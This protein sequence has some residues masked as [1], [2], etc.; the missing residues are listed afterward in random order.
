ME[1]E[2]ALGIVRLLISGG[3]TNEEAIGNPAIPEHYRKQIQEILEREENIIL[4]PARML[5][6]DT[7]KYDWLR[8]LDRSTWHYWPT[9][10][11]YLLGTKNWTIA[12]IRSLDE[13]TDR[14]L[15]QF[16]DPNTEQFDIRGLVVGYVQSGKTANFTALIAKAAD[17]GYRLV[18]VLSGTD[19]GLRRQTQIRLNRELVGYTNNPVGAIPLPPTGKQWHQFTTEEFDGDFHPGFANYA[20]LQG[21]EPVLLVVKKNG[22]VLRR[23]HDWLDAAPDNT[24]RTLP[25]LL[26]DDEADQ[27]SIDT[28]VLTKRKEKNCLMTM[29]NLLLLTVVYGIYCENSSAKLM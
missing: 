18:I 17:V 3:I 28:R 14:I 21:T 13:V 29:K 11:T 19:N 4:E 1:F 24:R 23:L 10:R 6:A 8:Q 20:A 9:L 15:G 25:V 22:S 12:S 26:I 5:V 27:A 7:Q 16:V 2:Q